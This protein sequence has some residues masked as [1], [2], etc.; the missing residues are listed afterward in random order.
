MIKYYFGYVSSFG[1][2][3]PVRWTEDNGQPIGGEV[4]FIIDNRWEITY[5]QWSCA[6]LSDLQ[7][8]YTF[9][10]PSGDKEVKA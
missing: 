9:R 2:P 6:H 4:K 8:K 10:E 7:V 1:S 3:S 5:K